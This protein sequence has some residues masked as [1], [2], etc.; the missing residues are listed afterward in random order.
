MLQV[1]QYQKTGELRVEELPEPRLR[2]GAVLVAN[3]YSLISAG[4]ERTSVETA[5][6]SV[7]GKA[8]SRPDLLQQVVA[9]AKREGVV[10]TYRKVQTRLD[11]Y[12]ELGYS[13]AGVVLASAVDGIAAGDRVACAGTAHHAEMVVVAKHLVTPIPDGVGFDEAAFVALGAIALQGV[14]QADVRI[15]ESVAVIGLGLVGLLTVQLLKAQGCRV[16]ALDVNDA[17]F[18]LARELGCDDCARSDEEAALAVESFTRGYGTDAVIITASTASNQ[19]LELAL[20]VARRRS[21]IV[22][23][24]AV[25][26]TVPRAPFYDKEVELKISASYGPGRYDPGYEDDGLDYPIDYVRWTENRNMAAVLSL[27]ADRRLD[28]LSLVT[29]RIPIGR[30]SDAYDLITGKTKERYLAVLLEYPKREAGAAALVPAAPTDR[31]ASPMSGVAQVAIGFI[32][33]GNFA[34]SYLLPPLV[35]AK[36]ELRGVATSRPVTAASAQR[37]FGFALS[38][39]DPAT[40]F[41]DEQTNAV[42]IAT[43]H[44]SHARYVCEALSGGRHV[45]VEK[46]LAVTYEQLSEVSDAARAAGSRGLYLAVGFNRRFSQPFRDIL[47]FFADRREPLAITYRVNAGRIPSSSWVQAEEQ[48]GRIIGE[49]CHFVDVFASLTGASPRRV[50]AQSARSEN[51]QASGEDSASIVVSYDDGSIATLIY[52]ANGDESVPKEYCEVSAGGKTA[53]MHDFASVDFHSGRSKK[54][55]SYSGGKGHAEEVAS[56]LDV[57]RGRLPP[58]FDLASLAETTVVTFAARDSLRTSRPVDL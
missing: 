32:G 36:I 22:I 53:I 3:E 35:K 44:D 27:L 41:A 33:A 30:A 34:Q 57:V 11:N 24:G 1:T 4:T 5:Q 6:A 45:F 31:G 54:R 7:I 16:I 8:R 23:V 10:A 18:A 28:V 51:V 15:G 25:G 29:H 55:R 14:R 56:F 43:R 12:K 38:S 20:E 50:Y 42:F 40:V 48:G 58:V 2:A 52:L 17:N 26:M 19:P 46:P 37:K 47:E 21:T 39:T 13:S 49:G 9:N